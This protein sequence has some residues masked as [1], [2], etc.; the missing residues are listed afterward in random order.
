MSTA[1]QEMLGRI[2]SGLADVPAAERPADVGV[3]RDYRRGGELGPE[4]RVELLRERLLDYHAEV[5]QA[6]PETIGQVVAQACSRWGLKTVVVPPELES[7]WRPAGVDVVEDRGLTAAELDGIDGAVTGCAGAIAQT[8]TL[9]LDGRGACGRRVITLVPDHHI[10]VVTA[11]QVIESV[12]EGVAALARAVVDDQ[13]PVTLIS[14]PSASSDIELARVEGVHGPRNLLVV[15][16]GPA[17]SG[18]PRG[19][20]G[21]RT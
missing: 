14:G 12:P 8:G 7:G 6:M 11:E 4:A 19:V 2:R 10:C 15:I 5:G 16:A 3:S 13:A 20:S 9:L 1:R 21:Q 17:R 18:R